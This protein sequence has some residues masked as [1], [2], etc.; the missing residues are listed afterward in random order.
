MPPKTRRGGRQNAAKK[1]NP[2]NNKQDV[3]TQTE[4]DLNCRACF[5]LKN[6]NAA[7]K[8]SLHNI[9]EIAGKHEFP[10]GN[11]TEDKADPEKKN[12][13]EQHQQQYFPSDNIDV[14]AI[15]PLL[16]YNGDEEA[17]EEIIEGSKLYLKAS[18]TEELRK[19]ENAK[20][21]ARNILDYLLK[22][23]LKGYFIMGRNGRKV[24]SYVLNKAIDFIHQVEEDKGWAKLSFLEIKN[25]FINAASKKK[26]KPFEASDRK[27]IS[28]KKIKRQI[29]SGSENENEDESCSD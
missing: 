7:Y 15:R 29:N 6:E 13:D 8:A 25:I 2:I 28:R 26:N 1:V 10:K 14:A 3:E 9:Y 4:D 16:K 22:D 11:S 18:G 19:S 12:E 27:N 20:I 21:I 24:P 5:A 23:G 17:V